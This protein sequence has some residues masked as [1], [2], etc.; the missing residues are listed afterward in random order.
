MFGL[1]NPH[2]IKHALTSITVRNRK[3]L[4]SRNVTCKVFP[5][6]QRVFGTVNHKVPL[7]KLEH[8]VV[9][10]LLLNFL[11]HTKI[12]KYTMVNHAEPISLPL[13]NVIF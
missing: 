5:D 7:V 1:F 13:I 2:S 6:F 4:D 10:D 9:D 11:K 3:S 8:C 12:T